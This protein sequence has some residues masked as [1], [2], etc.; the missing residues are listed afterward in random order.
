LCRR[1]ETGDAPATLS[2][3]PN[4]ENKMQE[5]VPRGVEAWPIEKVI[6]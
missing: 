4:E 5:D 3:K 1:A 2:L 6:A